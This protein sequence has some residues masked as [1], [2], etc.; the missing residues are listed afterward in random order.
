MIDLATYEARHFALLHRQMMKQLDRQLAPL[1]LGPG[2]YLYLFALYIRDGRR[3]QELADLVGTD[4]AATTRALARLEKNGYIRRI[5]DPEDGRATRVQ[6]TDKGRQLRPTLEAAA[7]SSMDAITAGLK[8][9]ERRQL[10]G[11]LAKMAAPY[12]TPQA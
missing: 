8:Q 2:R 10:K 7:E 5:P 4:K 11:L 12:T 6:L 1:D 9:Q 3:Q